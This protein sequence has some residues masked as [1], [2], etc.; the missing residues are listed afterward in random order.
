MSPETVVVTRHPAVVTHLRRLGLIEAEGEVR[1]IEHATSADVA[2]KR[3]VGY[4]PYHLAAVAAE[5]IHVPLKLTRHD[6][7]RGLTP[8]RV[9]EIAGPPMRWTV[10]GETL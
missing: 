5:F 3:V 9:A 8:E 2:G 10:R 7:N 6:R 4:L 1:V